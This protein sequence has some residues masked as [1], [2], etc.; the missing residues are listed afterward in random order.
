MDSESFLRRHF[1][2]LQEGE[3]FLLRFKRESDQRVVQKTFTNKDEDFEMAAKMAT[4]ASKQGTNVYYG[5]NPYSLQSLL[6]EKKGRDAISRITHAYVDVDDVTVAEYPKLERGLEGLPPYET[7]ASTGGGY[8][9]LWRYEHA[10][11]N[12]EFFGLAQRTNREIAL[13][14]DGDTHATDPA[15]TFR[16][17]GTR[18]WKPKYPEDTYAQVINHHNERID[19]QHLIDILPREPAPEVT[20]SPRTHD[21]DSEEFYDA[22]DYIDPHS[23]SYDEWLRVLM[24]VHAFDSGPE[25]LDTAIRWADGKDNEVFTKW[26]SFRRE[27]SSPETVFYF[28]NKAGWKPPKKERPSVSQG[29]SGSF[30]YGAEAPEPKHK[31][32]TGIFLTPMSDFLGEIDAG[33]QWV[34]ED[35]LGKGG[36]SLLV[37]KQKVGKSTFAANIAVAVAAGLPFLGHK[38]H[39]GTVHIYSLEVHRAHIREQYR[40]LIAAHGLTSAPDIMIHASTNMIDDAF[41]EIARIITQTKPSMVILDPL[42]KVLGNLADSNDYMG[43]SRAMQPIIE[44]AEQAN[45]H[46]MCIHHANKSQVEGTDGVMGSVGFAAAVDLTMMLRRDK[47]ANI[48]TLDIEARHLPE[49]DTIAFGFDEN[50][51]IEELGSR[52]TVIKLGAEQRLLAHIGANPGISMAELKQSSGIPHDMLGPLIFRLV[53]AFKIKLDDKTKRYTLM[54]YTPPPPPTP[55]VRGSFIV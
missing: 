45:T 5:I 42:A 43:V 26:R 35:L 55:P 11:E 39:Q 28:A 30:D 29:T 21:I 44:L 2:D 37:A 33:P 46:I 16:L 36:T 1:Q 15:R 23:L 25:G 22:L 10:I 12:P 13:V 8:Q 34:I 6:Y 51:M 32:Q 20:S 19:L 3:V 17:P 54:S 14:L 48:R 7:M 50:R 18:N 47:E 40:K 52:D 4:N 49:S 41:T 38:T 53:N 31:T 9:I 24:A 27:G